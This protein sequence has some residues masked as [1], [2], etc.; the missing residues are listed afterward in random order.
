MTINLS[1]KVEKAIREK[2]ATGRYADAEAVIQ[3]GLRLLE[4]REMDEGEKLEAL[5]R[6]IAEAEAQLRRGEGTAFDPEEIIRESREELA[7]RRREG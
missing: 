6:D 2:I 1:P 7:R 3:A 4:E 5:R